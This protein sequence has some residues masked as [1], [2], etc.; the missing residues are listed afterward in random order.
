MKY[1]KEVL[2]APVM[3]A[4]RIFAGDPGNVIF[5]RGFIRASCHFPTA[6]DGGAGHG[7]ACVGRP[8]RS[9]ADSVAVD[10]LRRRVRFNPLASDPGPT[11]SVTGVAKR[12]RKRKQRA[13]I[14]WAPGGVQLVWAARSGARRNHDGVHDHA[15][16]A[17]FRRKSLYGER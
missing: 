4:D 3:M 9:A 17:L 7:S 1:Q 16:H 10:L 14:A 13:A 2:P 11:W 15:W 6:G 8:R 12:M 5:I